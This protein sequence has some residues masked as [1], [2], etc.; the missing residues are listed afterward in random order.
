MGKR[1]ISDK[2]LVHEKLGDEFE[3]ALSQYDT[4]R[5]VEVLIGEFLDADL[6][7]KRVLDVG[8]GL[9][10]FSKAL[11]DKGA[12]VV[13][14]DLGAQLVERTKELCGCEGVVGDVFELDTYFE[15]DHFDLIV[16]SECIEHTP[17]PN[18]AIQKMA[19]VLR[20]GGYVSL[21]TPNTVWWPVVKLATVVKF[22][23]FDGLENFSSWRS[24][25]KAIRDSNMQVMEMKG[26]HLFPFHFGFHDLS[27]WMDGNLQILNGLMMNLC[28]LAQKR[29]KSDEATKPT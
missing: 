22:R 9:G 19:S 15:K 1:E 7:G 28:I 16:S 2:E 24:L 25:K 12:E 10:F 11:V 5:R 8:C 14:F 21:S 6:S 27:R 20:P 13:A 3:K 4:A 17:D 26:L 29:E 23:P 18:L